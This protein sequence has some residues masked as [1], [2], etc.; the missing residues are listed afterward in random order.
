[1]RHPGRECGGFCLARVEGTGA[2]VAA[3][4]VVVVWDCGCGGGGIWLVDKV[5]AFVARSDEAQSNQ[6]KISRS[7]AVTTKTLL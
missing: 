3:T 1:L 5:R 6:G 7:V 2:V 4:T